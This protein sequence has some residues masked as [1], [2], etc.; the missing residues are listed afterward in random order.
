MEG[1]FR[2][3]HYL[4]TILNDISPSFFFIQELWLPYFEEPRLKQFFPDYNFQIATPDMLTDPEDKI[5]RPSQNWHGAG[6]AWHNS[7]NHCMIPVENV[8]ERFTGLKLEIESVTVFAISVY[9][10]THGKDD[11]FLVCIQNLSNY[12][13]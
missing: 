10:P 12:I 3:Q 8:N 6:I 7:L 9:F 1:F 4:S 2:N 5:C 13:E 11:E